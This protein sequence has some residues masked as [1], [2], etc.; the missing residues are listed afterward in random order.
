[1]KAVDNK[2]GSDTGIFRSLFPN[3]KSLAI[4]RSAVERPPILSH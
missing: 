3:K 4:A 1:M 2:V